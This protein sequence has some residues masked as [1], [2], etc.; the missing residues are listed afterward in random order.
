MRQLILFALLVV[1]LATPGKARAQSNEPGLVLRLSRDFGYGGR[2]NEIQGRFSMRA[3]T[4]PSVV[5]V[6]FY[7]DD[8]LV[9]SQDTSPYRFN[10]N[11][12]DFS[13]GTHRLYAIG[14]TNS[15]AMLRSVEFTRV[16]LTASGARAATIGLVVPLLVIL[17][18]LGAASA[19]LPRLLWRNQQHRPGNYGM[20][21]G[22]ICN[23]CGKPFAR[24]S[25]MP[26]LVVG[27]LARCPHCG[28]WSLAARAHP[29]RL[30]TA[31]AE[32]AL[33]EQSGQASAQDSK[34]SLRRQ[35]DD[36]QYES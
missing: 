26:N 33:M 2:N 30:E 3:E 23:H 20:A 24:N 5:R 36:S 18:A 15:G 21:G 35:I 25:W 7:I 14:E 10:F 11:T 31:E 6:D 9:H 32:L 17:A 29:D 22:A 12:N 34:E 28:K 8:Q 27:K 1:L 4:S 16:F 19:L 13:P